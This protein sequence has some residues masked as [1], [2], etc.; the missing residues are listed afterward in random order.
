MK[1]KLALVAGVAA[2]YVLGTRAGRERY[3]QLR[4]QARTMWRDPRVQQKVSDAEHAVQE[5]APDVRDVR[6]SV[7]QAA[8]SAVGSAKAATTRKDPDEQRDGSGI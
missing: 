6:D 1:G 8:R 7:T 4:D 5:K 3:D 2:G